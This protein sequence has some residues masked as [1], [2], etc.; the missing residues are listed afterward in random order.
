MKEISPCGI[1]IRLEDQVIFDYFTTREAGELFQ[2][3]IDYGF[4]RKPYHSDNQLLDF[5]FRILASHLDA[6]GRVYEETRHTGEYK[7]WREACLS[8]DDY[9]C[10]RCGSQD[11]LHV[12]HIKPYSQYPELRHSISNGITLCAGCH[13]LAHRAMTRRAAR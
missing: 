5:A 10:Q 13:K 4:H 1:R 6:D 9:T 12:H 7:A 2:A 8:R 3:M 11:N